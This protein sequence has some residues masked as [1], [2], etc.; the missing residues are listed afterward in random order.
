MRKDVFD[1]YP[2][3]APNLV[4]AFTEAKDRS[5]A[6]MLSGTA[7]HIPVPW[8]PT[9]ARAA[10]KVLGDDLWPYGVE[11]NRKTLEAFTRYA[12]EQRLTDRPLAVEDLFPASVQQS[13]RI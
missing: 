11:R 3:V 1:R 4:T 9:S 12:H 5:V 10:T 7:P 13:F 6:R 2:W 8:G